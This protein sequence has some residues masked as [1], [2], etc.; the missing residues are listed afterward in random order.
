MEWR[1]YI[2]VNPQVRNSVA[3]IAGTRIPVSVVLDNLAGGATVEEI[4]REYPS[5]TPKSI[6]AAL[7]YAAELARERIVALRT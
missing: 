3:C 6:S 7:A 1:D 4:V 5:L 2:S